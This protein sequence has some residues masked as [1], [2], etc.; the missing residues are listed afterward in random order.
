MVV[1]KTNMDEFGMGSTT[2]TSCV[3]RDVRTPGNARVPGLIRAFRGRR[4]R[5]RSA[6]WRWQRHR[7]DSTTRL[8]LRVV[9]LKPTYGLVSR[10]GLVVHASPRPHR[11][12]SRRSVEDALALSAMRDGDASDSR[13]HV[14]EPSGFSGKPRATT[15]RT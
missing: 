5:R 10:H 2:E 13:R 7:L 8:V 11:A 1:G 14:P 15:T 6:C 12:A 9:G 4:G 3:W